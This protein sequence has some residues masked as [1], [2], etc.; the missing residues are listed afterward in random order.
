VGEPLRV[1]DFEVN[2]SGIEERG[3]VGSKFV[4][5]SADEG[6][7]MIAAKYS[8]KNVSPRP[9]ALTAAPRLLLIDPL[10]GEYGPDAGKSAAYAA[11]VV[12][13][14]KAPAELAPNGSS[15]AAAVF[16]V[17]KDRFDSGTWLLAIG[18]K[19]GPRVSLAGV[20]ANAP[21]TP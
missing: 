12:A 6:Q 11:E 16:V 10:G 7:Q 5:E 15:D 21:T 2:V 18:G 8:V 9:A 1:G 14:D 20:G 13:E 4:H 19:T 3:S 17:P